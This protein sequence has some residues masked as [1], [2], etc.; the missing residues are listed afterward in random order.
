MTKLVSGPPGKIFLRK[1]TNRKISSIVNYR[2]ELMTLSEK[3]LCNNLAQRQIIHCIHSFANNTTTLCLLGVKSVQQIM[4]FMYAQI[5]GNVN[6]KGSLNNLK[7]AYFLFVGH[8]VNIR[9]AFWYLRKEGIKTSKLSHLI[10]VNH[11][12]PAQ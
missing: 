4:D 8:L 7:P 12:D 1:G 2:S 10:V 6:T 3:L 9:K 5:T 11:V